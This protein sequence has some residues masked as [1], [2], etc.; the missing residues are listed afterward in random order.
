MLSSESSWAW[1]SLV[2]S[3]TLLNFGIV[4]IVF[5]R[6]FQRF[7]RFKYSH[8]LAYLHFDAIQILNGIVFLRSLENASKLRLLD[9][10]AQRTFV[11]P[12]P[13]NLTV[14]LNPFLTE[15]IRILARLQE[16]TGNQFRLPSE[17]L[18]N[19]QYLSILNEARILLSMVEAKIFPIKANKIRL[20]NSIQAYDDHAS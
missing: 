10:N 16:Q 6:P 8:H 14:N 11:L 5:A 4:I 12:L 17:K 2:F 9:I 18:N 7:K 15:L 19:D 20:I 13:P 3:H 1:T